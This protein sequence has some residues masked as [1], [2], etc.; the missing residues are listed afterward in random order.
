MSELL[1]EEVQG[2]RVDARVDEAQAEADDL[3]DVPEHVVEAGV[4]V[5]PDDIDVAR[6]PAENE[7]NDEGEHHL[8]HLL[9]GLH[10][11]LVLV[12]LAVHLSCNQK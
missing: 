6:Q 9:T 1:T 11:L 2:Q 5:V 10:L 7:D 12:G 3:E 4:V 8:G